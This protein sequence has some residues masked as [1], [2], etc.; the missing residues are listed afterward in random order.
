MRKAGAGLL[1]ALLVAALALPGRA[2]TPLKV[3]MDT[4]SRP[5]AFVP[6]LDYSKENWTDAPKISQAQIAQLQGVDI[7]VLKALARRLDVVPEIVPIAW[8]DI[9]QGLL[10]KRFDII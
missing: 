10:A 6:G 7:D 4:R 5:W 2:A 1:A 8:A 9:D 3:G